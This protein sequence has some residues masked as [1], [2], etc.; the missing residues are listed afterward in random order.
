MF[1]MLLVPSRMATLARPLQT[2]PV[3]FQFVKVF[4]FWNNLHNI[5]VCGV[6][7]DNR[8]MLTQVEIVHRNICLSMYISITQ[9]IFTYV[10]FCQDI[11]KTVNFKTSYS[12]EEKEG[13]LHKL[14][15]LSEADLH[16]YIRWLL[17][18]DWFL[19]LRF[20]TFSH[21]N[22]LSK[23]MSKTI[24]QHRQKSGSFDCVEQLLDLPKM[25]PKIVQKV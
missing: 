20:L 1:Q 23:K 21:V 24:I 19:H 10:T 25:D 6:N 18:A 2:A 4:S 3:T 11:Y 14:N 5:D 15:K 22:I 8:P 7:F 9:Y 17:L 13:I 12:D 16:S